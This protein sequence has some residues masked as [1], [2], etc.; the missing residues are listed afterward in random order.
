MVWYASRTCRGGVVIR[1]R[2]KCTWVPSSNRLVSWWVQ[3]LS[4]LDGS[5]SSGKLY[6]RACPYSKTVQSLISMSHDKKSVDYTRTNCLKTGRANQN[7]LAGQ[8]I[9]IA[10]VSL[11]SVSLSSTVVC[12][13]LPALLSVMEPSLAPSSSVNC[14]LVLGFRVVC[15]RLF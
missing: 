4:I 5:A 6:G 8:R 9:D 7:L 3:Y 14:R 15:A 13:L 2:F 1:T 10:D 11:I 12:F